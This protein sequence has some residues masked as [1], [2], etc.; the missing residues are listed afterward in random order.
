[1]NRYSLLVIKDEAVVVGLP[2]MSAALVVVR[3]VRGHNW[4]QKRSAKLPK[5]FFS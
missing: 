5:E 3:D 2:A 4:K 1:M